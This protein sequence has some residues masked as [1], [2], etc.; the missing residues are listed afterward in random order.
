[1]FLGAVSASG[2][3]FIVLSLVAPERFAGIR[4]KFHPVQRSFLCGG[5]LGGA[6]LGAGMAVGGACPGM[7]LPQVGTG[8]PNALLTT[9]GGL[10]GALCFGLLE[11]TFRAGFLGKGNLCSGTKEDFLDIKLNKP[12]VALCLPFTVMCGVA[13][14]C[15][16]LFFP[17]EAELGLEP[18]AAGAAA[19][20]FSAK[21]WPPALCGACLGLLQLVA[22]GLLNDSL[23]SSTAYTCVASQWLGLVGDGIRTRCSYLESNRTGVDKWWQVV[24][25]PP[26]HGEGLS[27]SPIFAAGA[28]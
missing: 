9:L 20:V 10:V 12:F 5:A 16:E 25:E 18:G 24:C 23:G 7:V 6:I 3:S 4:A 1:M 17:Y 19:Q 14:L 22:G 28:D 11:P 2:F 27:C 26:T 15:L 8:L 13:A 21:A